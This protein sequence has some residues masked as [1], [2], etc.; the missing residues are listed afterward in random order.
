MIMEGVFTQC[1]EI[2]RKIHHHRTSLEDRSGGFFFLDTTTQNN[3][4][5]IILS[6]HRY[7]RVTVACLIN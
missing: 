5:P 6:R 3:L 7:H 4:I 2:E 1:Y